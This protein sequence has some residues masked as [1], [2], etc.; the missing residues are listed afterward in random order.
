MGSSPELSRDT[1]GSALIRFRCKRSDHARRS[2]RYTLTIYQRMWA[3]CAHE[4]ATSEHSWVA[5]EGI[6]LQRL[7]TQHRASV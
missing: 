6:A 4:G 5:I 3:F 7:L 2:Q 1:P